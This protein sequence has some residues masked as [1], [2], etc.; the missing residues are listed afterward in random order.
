MYADHSQGPVHVAPMEKRVRGATAALEVEAPGSCRTSF[1]FATQLGLAEVEACRLPFYDNTWQD[2]WPLII[3]YQLRSTMQ[4]ISGQS[5]FQPRRS[6]GTE[7]LE[8]AGCLARKIHCKTRIIY[9]SESIFSPLLNW[10]ALFWWTYFNLKDHCAAVLGEA[11][12]LVR[13]FYTWSRVRSA[14]T[15]GKS[16]WRRSNGRQKGWQWQ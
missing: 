11:Q 2:P 6:S 4:R 12:M 1:L 16:T 14:S 15:P 3:T 5:F 8:L 13:F 7:Q 9:W 10:L